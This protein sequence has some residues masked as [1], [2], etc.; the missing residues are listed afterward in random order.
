VIFLAF[1]TQTVSGFGS[2][3][4]TVALLAT[5]LELKVIVPMFTIIGLVGQAMILIRFR[6]AFHP[7]AVLRLGLAAIIG[8]VIG[9][10]VLSSVNNRLVLGMLGAF[11][12]SYAIYAL[13]NFQLPRIQNPNWGYGFGLVSG[14]FM[15]MYNTGGPP[16][17]VY[18]TCRGWEPDEFRVNLQSVFLVGAT[19]AILTHLH[20]GNYTPEVLHY[21]M[22]AVPGL[23]LGVLTG[24]YVDRFINPIIFRKI[25]FALVIV[26]GLNLLIRALL[27]G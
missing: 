23:I 1:F 9:V 25:V 12:V 3:L 10:Y 17:I 15:G 5:V 4:I 18:G 27:G 11:L 19:A 26:L 6:S 22:Y 24:F 21:V 2:G 7:G 13:L 14:M 20:H 8:T 16:L